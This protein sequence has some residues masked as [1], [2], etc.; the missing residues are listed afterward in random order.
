MLFR[1]IIPS[2]KFRVDREREI[3]RIYEDYNFR[4]SENLND[5][6]NDDMLIMHAS[7]TQANRKKI[8]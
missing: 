3:D 6:G 8:L 4:F 7:L 2:E 1:P 5:P